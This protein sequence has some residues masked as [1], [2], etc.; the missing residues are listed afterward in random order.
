MVRGRMLVCEGQKDKEESREQGLLL[1]RIC[2]ACVVWVGNLMILDQDC[3]LRLP[4]STSQANH[5]DYCI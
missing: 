3:D 4:Q 2:S 5:R 1:M